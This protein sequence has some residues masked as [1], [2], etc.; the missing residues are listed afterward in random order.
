MLGLEVSLAISPTAVV[1]Q[2]AIFFGVLVIVSALLLRPMIRLNDARH[3]ATTL[4]SNH[5]TQLNA[6]AATSEDEYRTKIDAALHEARQ[7]KDQQRQAG[8][9]E[10]TKILNAAR[11]Q[12]LAQMD[13]AKS[14]LQKEVEAAK[15]LLTASAADFGRTIAERVLE[16]SL[17]EAV[18]DVAKGPERDPML[19]GKAN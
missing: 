1:I 14:E 19:I 11:T 15:Q 12:A 7:S 6:G 4:R 8:F 9:A 2:A 10:A 13:A 16:R 17:E 18:G 5:A 3:A